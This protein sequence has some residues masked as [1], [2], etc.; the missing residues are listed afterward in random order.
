MAVRTTHDEVLT[1]MPDCTVA[2][3]TIDTLIIAASAVVD[4]VFEDDTT[5]GDT[6]KEEIEKWLTAHMI[7]STLWRTTSEEKLGDATVKYTGSWGTGLNSTPYGQMVLT[8]D[9]TGK[10]SKMGK[11]A[12]SIYAIKSFD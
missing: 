4:E 10:M 6:L 9:F 11:S 2:H 5:I 1:I 3:A 8:L 7:A 12:A